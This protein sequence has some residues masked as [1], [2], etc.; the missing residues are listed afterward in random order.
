MTWNRLILGLLLALNLL[1]LYR[2]LF[3]DQGMISYYE[4]GARQAE[5]ELRIEELDRQN[6]ALSQEIRLLKADREHIEDVIRQQ[7]HF[8]KEDEI[9][10]IFPNQAADTAAGAPPDDGKN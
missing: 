3:S 5:L 10:Y 8:V 2:F 4:L 9:L 6:L 1:L 7:M